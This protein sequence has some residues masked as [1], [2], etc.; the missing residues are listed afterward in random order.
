MEEL[1]IKFYPYAMRVAHTLLTNYKIKTYEAE[2]FILSFHESMIKCV[3]VFNPLRGDFTTFF[4]A[5]YV[6]N[7]YSKL[8][9]DYE[10]NI[11][12]FNSISL[13]AAI[14]KDGSSAHELVSYPGNVSKETQYLRSGVQL[15]FHDYIPRK[16]VREKDKQE[17]NLQKQFI[18]LNYCGYT[19]D[20]IGKMYG[21]TKRV[22]RRIISD[23]SLGSPLRD[24]KTMFDE[25]FR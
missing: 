16:H 5:I 25:Y 13:D 17:N 14:T 11:I 21:I 6:Q 18:L 9:K 3:R 1:E 2:D 12:L 15:V 20:E 22:V 7:I 19:Y 24:L 8:E 4:L 10:N 23:D